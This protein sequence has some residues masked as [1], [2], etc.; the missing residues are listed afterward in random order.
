MT[1]TSDS[2][3]GPSLPSGLRSERLATVQVCLQREACRFKLPRLTVGVQ[4]VVLDSTLLSVICSVTTLTT[5]INHFLRD[6]K[7]D[8]M[9]I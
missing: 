4:F 7:A 5:D 6:C 2:T 8:S 3:N 1:S 9:P